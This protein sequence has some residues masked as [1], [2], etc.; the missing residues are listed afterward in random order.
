MSN[1]AITGHTS[2]L[3]Y[4]LGRM[5]PDHIGLSRS[6][7][8]DISCPGTINRIVRECNETELFFNNAHC[9]FF[10][11][12]LLYSL[13]EQ[14]KDTDKTIVNISSV[15][16]ETSIHRPHKYA[17]EKLALD[18][19]TKQL[20]ANSQC[21]IVLVKVGLIDTPRSESISG[22]KMPVRFVANQIKIQ[23]NNDA[24]NDDIIYIH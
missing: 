15:S 22:N 2:G 4:E 16:P 6:N 5:Y 19:A 11:V 12:D 13:Y 14:W 7:G 23:L 9:G 1:V 20:N 3:G 18:A 24:V 10:Q 8:H 17:I 21:R